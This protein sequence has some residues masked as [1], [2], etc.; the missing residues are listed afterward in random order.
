REHNVFVWLRPWLQLGF[1]ASLDTST[2]YVRG[3][4]NDYGPR[5][6]SIPI[7]LRRVHCW[8]AATLFSHED[9]RLWPHRSLRL[10]K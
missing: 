4:N 2:R 8:G 3:A 5:A 7:N 1:Y 10:S 6:C 9:V